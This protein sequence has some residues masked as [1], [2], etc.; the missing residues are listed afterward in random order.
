MHAWRRVFGSRTIPVIVAALCLL[1]LT[2]GCKKD[3]DD[4]TTPPP[5]PT[6]APAS[7]Y[8]SDVA[9]TW[10]SKTYDLVKAESLAPTVASRVYGYTS[11]TIYQAT[12]GGMPDYVS[13]AGLL[14]DLT[15]VPLPADTLE[16]HWPTVVN[17][18]VALLLDNLLSANSDAAIAAL[19]DLL[20]AEY[21]A[22][23]SA[24]IY[25]RSA[26]F[27]ESVGLAIYVWSTT[28]GFAT[29]NNCAYTP[30]TGEGLWVPTPPGFLA[31]HQPCWGRLRPFALLNSD[32][33]MCP[34][35]CVY[36]T[37]D[38]SEFWAQAVEVLDAVNN[39]SA[40]DSA[41]VNF[42]ADGP[43]ATGTPGGH[44]Q[45]ILTQ[46]LRNGNYNLETAAEAYAR[47]G[48][49]VAD[50]FISCWRAKY[51]YNLCRP[52]TYIQAYMSA[53]W[54]SMITTPNF[55]EYTSGHSV[56]SGAAAQ[57]MTDLFGGNYAFVDSTHYPTR[58]PRSFTSF[59]DAANE[60][61]ISRLY[62]GIHYRDAIDNGI[63][64]GHCV[65]AKASA[66]PLNINS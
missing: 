24:D 3:D 27:G 47:V 46:V 17:S 56:Q 18:A 49:A 39:A 45:M 12:V 22:T 5:A 19:R 52:V 31:A 40:E 13:L 21:Q 32:E 61:A 64:Q 28:D 44:S 2:M 15:S 9:T 58:A 34:S 14:N 26:T 33:C 7:S 16:Y 25:T 6:S 63:E 37:S 57:V 42:W 51:I 66:L 60:A 38:T 4:E 50:A 41:I 59:E 53:S 35:H 48:V 10:M 54:T 8:S 55:P 43:G 65:G 11:V 20:A 30:P 62:G 1:L 29:Y 36:S 23:I